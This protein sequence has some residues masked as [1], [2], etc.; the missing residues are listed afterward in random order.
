[1]KKV[2]LA[3][4][5]VMLFCPGHVKAAASSQTKV[6]P[7]D[8]IIFIGDSRTL[9]MKNAVKDDSIWSCENSMGY[10]WMVS[11]GV[12]AIEKQIGFN[13]A[14]VILMG[15]NDIHNLSKYIA[16]VNTKAAEWAV[17]GAMTYFVSVGPVENDP[18][19]TNKEIKAFNAGLKKGLSGVTYINIYS[20]LVKNGYSTEDGTH[21]TKEVSVSIYDYILKKLR[22]KLTY[23]MKDNAAT[24]VSVRDANLRTVTIPA[25]IKAGKKKI[26]V[27]AILARAFSNMKKLKSLTIGKNMKTIG[28]N[29][30]VNCTR[31]KQIRILTRKL[32]KKTVKSNA[33]GN[34][35]AY[36][37]VK[38]PSGLTETYNSILRKRGMPSTVT[39]E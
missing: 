30:F 16:Y 29:A 22:G 13:T 28:N 21:Y 3:C 31:L 2:I 4:L 7:V 27:T 9:A 32:T 34:I 23:T 24:I 37:V 20:Y 17:K 18:Y 1:M 11:T 39:F 19:V 15:V 36:A 38:C 35:S 25:S 6:S 10:E 5:L 12:P 33:F 14:V 26:P 8:K